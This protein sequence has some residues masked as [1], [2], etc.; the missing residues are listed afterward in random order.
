MFTWNNAHPT[1]AQIVVERHG[2]R[3]SYF[4]FEDRD[5]DDV[6]RIW[7]K[8]LIIYFIK[9]IQKIA[10]VSLF[11]DW[12]VYHAISTSKYKETLGHTSC[13]H[14]VSLQ[15][16]WRYSSSYHSTETH[17]QCYLKFQ[18]YISKQFGQFNSDAKF[19]D[20]HFLISDKVR[21]KL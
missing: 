11:C 8:N 5:I 2:R 17:K 20:K 7:K 15:L 19:L 18:A 6:T 16:K 14:W 10:F 21:T 13:L 4:I 1:H 12:N 3:Q 9:Q